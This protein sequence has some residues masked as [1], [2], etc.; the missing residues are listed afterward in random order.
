MVTIGDSVT[1]CDGKCHA[2][3]KLNTDRLPHRDFDTQPDSYGNTFSVAF[4]HSHPQ[5]LLDAIDESV[6]FTHALRRAIA[7]S[8]R[9]SL[10]AGAGAG[11]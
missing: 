3:V 5:T 6:R 7:Y 1:I 11:D 8:D 10:Y 4:V 9:A 2:D